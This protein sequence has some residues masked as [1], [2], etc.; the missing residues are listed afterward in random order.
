VG[1]GWVAIETVLEWEEMAQQSGLVE[2]LLSPLVS[3]W[4]VQLVLAY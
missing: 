2:G 1:Q 4:D 3:L